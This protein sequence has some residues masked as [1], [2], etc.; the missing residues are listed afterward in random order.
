MRLRTPRVRPAAATASR[1]SRRSRSWASAAGRGRAGCLQALHERLEGRLA[2]AEF[3]ATADDAVRRGRPAPARA[4]V[5]VVTDGEQ[6]RDSYASFVGGRLDN[7][8]L[9]PLTDLLPYVEDPDE[10]A[11][12]L[13]ALDVPAESVRHPAVFGRLARDR[14][15]PSPCTSWPAARRL[16]DRPVKVALPGPYL[17]TR[18]MWL[19][20]VSDRAY[21][22]AR[23][24]RAKTSSGCCARRSRTCSRPARRSCSSTSRC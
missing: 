16:T 8:Q 7:C 21:A 6:R 22:D 18:T 10:F 12:E 15:G 11:R 13:R 5:D 20:C 3:Q 4:G 9:I 14:R 1:P 19:E 17:L 2:E 24:A 23:G